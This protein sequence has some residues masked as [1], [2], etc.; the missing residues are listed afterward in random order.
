MV[1]YMYVRAFQKKNVS[2]GLSRAYSKDLDYMMLKD[3]QISRSAAS[4][5]LVTQEDLVLQF[6]S[7]KGE[8]SKSRIYPFLGDQQVSHVVLF[9][10]TDGMSHMNITQL[11]YSSTN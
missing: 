9:R 11:I 8:D 1:C 2:V 7:K 10:P 3:R 5:R 4:T 6:C